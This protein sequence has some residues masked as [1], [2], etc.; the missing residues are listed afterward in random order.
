MFDNTMK[1]ICCALVACTLAV[2]CASEQETLPPPI[3]DARKNLVYF[4][5]EVFDLQLS[6]SIRS[7]LP[8][9]TVTPADKMTINHIPARLNTWLAA[10]Q[11]QGGSV[12]LVA[13]HKGPDG[14]DE[15]FIQFLVPIA[16]EMI[17]NFV[18]REL[19]QSPTAS[20]YADNVSDYIKKDPLFL[21]AKNM[22]VTIR[23]DDK[24]KVISEIQF[25]KVLQG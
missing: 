2:G 24:S 13:R 12:N 9:I 22:L 7:Q 16:L 6:Q 14:K 10:V 23:Y 8:L 21:G 11:R 3:A 1:K 19:G 17:A 15:E 20:R 25:R 5:S 18:R 4:D